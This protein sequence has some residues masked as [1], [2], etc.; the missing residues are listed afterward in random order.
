MKR[1]P[2]KLDLDTSELLFL[3]QVMNQREG[4]PTT[5]VVL[6]L[7]A[8]ELIAVR[9][10]QSKQDLRSCLCFQPRMGDIGYADFTSQD[11]I[12]YQD[13]LAD[14]LREETGVAYTGGIRTADLSIEQTMGMIHLLAQAVDSDGKFN[15]DQLE[16]SLLEALHSLDIT[17]EQLFPDM[18]D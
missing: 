9:R 8:D 13:D 17:P 7:S 11:M 16:S 4:N 18:N 2:V 1:Y 5:T 10:D 6:E 3:H 14:W 15:P 12:N